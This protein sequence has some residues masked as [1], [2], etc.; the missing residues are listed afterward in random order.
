MS[1]LCERTR[2]LSF[3][4]FC[5]DSYR[6]ACDFQIHAYD[7]TTASF[8]FFSPSFL[9]H[10]HSKFIYYATFFSHAATP[11]T[12]N[13]HHFSSLLYHIWP[14]QLLNRRVLV[15]KFGLS[16]RRTRKPP[17]KNASHSI[18]ARI[19][20]ERQA[21]RSIR[22]KNNI[23]TAVF[24]SVE[25]TITMLKISSYILLFNFILAKKDRFCE[26]KQLIGY[27]EN[28][29]FDTRTTKTG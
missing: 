3:S 23:I 6:N 15:V 12:C 9:L 21:I 24:T 1:T 10:L 20:H 29:V 7:S 4:T 8:F 16:V 17:H 26:R 5:Y 25:R 13:S 27:C 14:L 18:S 28:R 22:A 11:S 2:V 19:L